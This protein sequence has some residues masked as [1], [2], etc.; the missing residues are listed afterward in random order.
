MGI[1]FSH[2]NVPSLSK[3]AIRSSIGTG[4]EPSSPHARATKSVMARRA[5]PGRQDCS[6]PLVMVSA[7]AFLLLRVDRGRRVETV[8]RPA[9]RGI[10]A[11]R[12]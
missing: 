4:V 10:S 12:S 9:Q 3:T 8:V 7:Q 5:G 11:A 6:D 1:G 2:H